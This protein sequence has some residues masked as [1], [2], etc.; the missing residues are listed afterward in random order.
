MTPGG[1]ISTVVGTGV[2]GSTGDGLQATAATLNAPIGIVIDASGNLYISE[3][4]ANR[5]RKVTA[6][7]GI[8]S[9]YAGTGS[10]ASGGDGGSALSAGIYNPMGLALDVDGNL[11]I[12]ESLAHRI[13]KMTPNGTI[14]TVAGTGELGLDKK[15]DLMATATKL[16]RPFAIEFD[17]AGN[18]YI[19]DTINSRI[20]R[21][22]K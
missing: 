21:V 15:D 11:Y 12:A 8:I 3:P 5:I 4:A 10:T 7:T 1:A 9:L 14:S 2:V 22:A 17:P 16:K 6:A 20:L 13:R 19:S 18:L